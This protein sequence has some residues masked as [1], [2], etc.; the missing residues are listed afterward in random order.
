M[1]GSRLGWLAVAPIVTA[2]N[3][4]AR[5][6]FEVEP[7]QQLGQPL[8]GHPQRRR[9]LGPPAAGLGEGAADEAALEHLTRLVQRGHAVGPA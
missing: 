1:R 8:P 9:R 2:T 4:G 5:R 6:I 7:L 3:G